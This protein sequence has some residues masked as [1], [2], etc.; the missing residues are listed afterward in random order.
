M[1]QMLLDFARKTGY[2]K[3]RL[4]T[5][6]EQKQA[7]ALKLYKRL[8]F[9]FIERYNDSPC[10]VFMEKMLWKVIT[11]REPVSAESMF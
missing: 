4:D 5:V 8:G 9:Y 3:V 1:T 10:T 7:Q 2:K 11:S 6:D